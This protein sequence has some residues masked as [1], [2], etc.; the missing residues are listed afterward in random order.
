MYFD[1][2]K[3]V[4][5]TIALIIFLSQSYITNFSIIKI[6][7]LY[8]IYRKSNVYCSVLHDIFVGEYTDFFDKLKRL[9]KK[10]V[11]GYF[12]KSGG[13]LYGKFNAVCRNKSNKIILIFRFN[14]VVLS[15]NEA[16]IE[17]KNKSFTEEE[18]LTEISSA[19]QKHL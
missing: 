7:L 4:I 12:L 3:W 10:Q 9:T 17:I 5:I 1:R 2:D 16:K 18:L 11:I 19:I 14:K 8:Y 13:T 15:V 6:E